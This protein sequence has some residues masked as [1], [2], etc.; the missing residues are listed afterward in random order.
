M[1]PHH[2]PAA[3][4]GSRSG[5]VLLV[6]GSGR[7]EQPDDATPIRPRAD[8]RSERWASNLNTC[9]V[10][11]EDG[12]LV[13]HLQAGGEFGTPIFIAKRAAELGLEPDDQRLRLN[14]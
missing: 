8:R 7:R 14:R 6:D 13:T 3:G 12:E 10:W 11:A 9:H 5:A 1:H 2:G 4:D